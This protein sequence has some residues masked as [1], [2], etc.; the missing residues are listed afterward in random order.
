M[1]M[2]KNWCQDIYGWEPNPVKIGASQEQNT[3]TFPH[4][5]LSNSS[6]AKWKKKYLLFFPPAQTPNPGAIIVTLRV[7]LIHDKF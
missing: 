6:V 2:R 7:H 5:M 3:I 4:I 1:M